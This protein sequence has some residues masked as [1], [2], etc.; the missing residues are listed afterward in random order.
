MN[1]LECG[2][3][4]TTILVVEDEEAV[5][6][7]LAEF[8]TGA[9]YLVLQ[10]PDAAS[11]LMIL[12]KESVDA[13]TIDLK[14]P[15]LDG[16]ELATL[17][18]ETIPDLPLIAVTAYLLLDQNRSLFNGVVSK[19]FQIEELTKT[20]LICAPPDRRRK[21]AT[22][23]PQTLVACLVSIRQQIST[24]KH[25]LYIQQQTLE[26]CSIGTTQTQFP[27]WLEDLLR[28]IVHDLR[29]QLSAIKNLVDALER[30]ADL[31][32]RGVDPQRF[33]QISLPAAARSLERIDSV[34]SRLRNLA[35]RVVTQRRTVDINSLIEKVTKR[36][37]VPAAQ[38]TRIS[39]DLADHPILVTGDQELLEQLVENLAVN[40]I[41]ACQMRLGGVVNIRT[42]TD[43][44]RKI[45]VLEVTDNG[46]GMKSSVLS[47]IYELNY[48]TKETG[49]GLGLFLAKKAVDEHHGSINCQ[50]VE[51]T[52]TTFIVKLP[53]TTEA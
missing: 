47:K 35:G 36:L 41:E 2:Q 23:S 30:R 27:P 52:G 17:L 15:G 10:A 40:A 28:P 45:L 5:R 37:I 44:A 16:L 18:R 39:V 51:G 26:S 22:L 34:L 1:Q 12:L 42:R 49:L 7:I 3:D 48:T 31:V 53:L 38:D 8:L 9:G 33:V 24:L 29:N 21:G 11:A 25:Q 6:A 4:K 20:L 13:V 32:A 46:I 50:T 43:P 19:P 14:L